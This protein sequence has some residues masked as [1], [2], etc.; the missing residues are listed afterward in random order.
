MTGPGQ[1]DSDAIGGQHQ[2]LSGP[3]QRTGRQEQSETFVP[4]NIK[5]SCNLSWSMPQRS[6][7]QIWGTL[8]GHC[9]V[10]L[11]LHASSPPL[12]YGSMLFSFQV[13]VPSFQTLEKSSVYLS[14]KFPGELLY[15]KKKCIYLHICKYVWSYLLSW[16]AL[17]R[18]RE[19]LQASC[20]FW[21][22]KDF[23]LL[24]GSALSKILKWKDIY[25]SASP[26]LLPL[27]F[28]LE[29]PFPSILLLSGIHPSSQALE[30]NAHRF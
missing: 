24:A 30:S 21:L 15:V 7:G 25:L 28:S 3:W 11:E 18:A 8:R 9:P 17:G 19:L 14:K 2:F 23:S 4:R 1:C 5:L 12:V 10:V 26:F 29:S 16:W 6:R 27:A 13:R 22:S 20:L